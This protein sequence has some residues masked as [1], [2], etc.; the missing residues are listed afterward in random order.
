MHNAHT[1]LVMRFYSP[2]LLFFFVIFAFWR[3]ML[4]LGSYQKHLSPPPTS[5]QAPLPRDHPA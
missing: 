5:S 3:R 2:S 4:F 1:H